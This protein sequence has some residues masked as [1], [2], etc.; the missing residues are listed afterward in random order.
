MNIDSKNP[1]ISIIVPTFNRPI[2][3]ARAL[4]SLLE[5]TYT[6]MEI[7]VVNDGGCDVSQMIASLQDSRIVLLVHETNKGLPAARNTALHHATGDYIAYLD[8]D[9]I[10]YPNHLKIMVEALQQHP[11]YKVVCTDWIN[12]FASFENGLPV[13]YKREKATF[14]I[15][16]PS[17]LIDN[18]RPIQS[19]MHARSCLDEIGYFD[20]SLKRYEDWEVWIRLRQKYPFLHISEAEIEYTRSD[21]TNHQQM[22]SAWV[23]PFLQTMQNIHLRYYEPAKLY[24]EI[25]ERQ[26][27]VRNDL[28][29]RVFQQLLEMADDDLYQLDF[30]E[31][32]TDIA[33]SSLLLTR[34]DVKGARALTGFFTMHF[35]EKA[36]VWLLHARL[37]REL[38]DLQTAS[39]A[40]QRALQLEET[41]VVL[42]ELEILK[43]LLKKA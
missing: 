37:C 43:K 17:I 30:E 39:I 4:K 29:Y 18:R 2:L 32:L 42:N 40:L 15:S 5:Q 33:S 26:G 34:E 12:A 13:V 23:G 22:V 14:E 6:N 28:R 31:W 21:P 11:E 8:D 20:E 9:D 41:E 10:Y 27:D 35:P 19:I 36:R 7:I 38:G 16:W 3:L 25:L 1:K 24:P